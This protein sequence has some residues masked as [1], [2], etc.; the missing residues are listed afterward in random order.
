[1][2]NIGTRKESN[3]FGWMEVVNGPYSSGCER[4][5]TKVDVKFDNT[6]CIRKNILTKTFLLGAVRD[7]SILV[8][9]LLD[10][11]A[12]KTGSYGS[13]EILKYKT[14]K[15]VDIRFVDTGNIQT[16]QADNLL[17]G[18]IT[19]HVVRDVTNA[20]TKEADRLRVEAHTALMDSYAERRRLLMV[21]REERKAALE[22]SR[23]KAE[24]RSANFKARL[25]DNEAENLK[26]IVEC[27]KPVVVET[28]LSQESDGVLNVDFKDRDGKWVLRYS[29]TQQGGREFVQTR[30]GK[31]HNNMTQRASKSGSVQNIHNPA[32]K[33]VV[34][35]DDFKD[36]QKFCDWAVNQPGWGLG[37]S[38]EKDLLVP[39]NRE[40]AA[41]KCVFLP[42][43]INYAIVK[44]SSGKSAV[45]P[46]KGGFR[47][48]TSIGGLQVRLEVCDT[49]EEAIQMYK[50][51]RS[52]YVKRL[53]VEYSETISP[54]AYDALMKWNL[55][56]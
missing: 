26:R 55:D 20:V 37:Y 6:G 47:A 32:Y 28:N 50:D 15:A 42:Q 52:A 18:L 44:L 46:F 56:L 16:V 3:N 14:A 10:G 19:D 13:V 9:S 2:V 25:E 22:L 39:G 43:V 1:M 45:V 33:G 53:A 8:S 27:V 23:L 36:P 7:G 31:L 49:Y 4:N 24:Q 5:D 29:R 35:S 17:T 51:Y 41:D 30:L 48:K 12:F 54:V 21:K 40:Y 34:V 11:R 38:L